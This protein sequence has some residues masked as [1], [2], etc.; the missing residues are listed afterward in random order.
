MSV[1]FDAFNGFEV[2]RTKDVVS[3]QR[4]MTGRDAKVP[5]VVSGRTL[6]AT[7]QLAG[8][9]PVTFRVFDPTL[10][11]RVLRALER[12]FAIQIGAAEFLRVSKARFVIEF[13]AGVDRT[14]FGVVRRRFRIAEKARML[15]RFTGLT[16]ERGGNVDLGNHRL[17]R[18][19]QRGRRRS[20]SPIIGIFGRRTIFLLVDRYLLRFG[21]LFI[22]DIFRFTFSIH[23]V[24]LFDLLIRVAYS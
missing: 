16:H 8:L 20:G 22:F 24:D 14:P 1:S 21:R 6:D 9:R 7:E 11:T 2:I 5:G 13:A 17:R 23:D 10:E 15:V 3:P 18:R 4:N 12:L 19:R